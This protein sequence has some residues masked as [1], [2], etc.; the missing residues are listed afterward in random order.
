MSTYHSEKRKA[1]SQNFI[2]NPSLIRYI[3]D[4]FIIPPQSLVLDIGA[5]EGIIAQ[6]LVKRGYTVQAYE[7]DNELTLDLQQKF[8]GTTVEVIQQDIRRIQYPNTPFYI[9]SN[10]PFAIFSEF[11]K[12]L[13]E[14]KNSP[15]G[16]LIFGQKEALE[17]VI[18]ITEM[19]IISII[20][21]TLYH[22]EII[23]TFQSTDFSPAPSVAVQL[24]RL[25][26]INTPIWDTKQEYIAFVSYAFS[27]QKSSLM[28]NVDSIF[29][30]EQWK[31]LAKTYQFDI[32]SQPRDLN[33]NQWKGLYSYYRDHIDIKKRI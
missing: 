22:S 16:A 31:R 3:L 10:P 13:Y 4:R 30:Y 19:S 23:Y 7:L 11:M 12:G 28:K 26:R 9:V 21:Q 15:E 5:G 33:I 1:Y 25:Q 2:K 24:L 29:T 18:G 20:L 8:A 32:K 27:Q 17:R 6:E 14:G